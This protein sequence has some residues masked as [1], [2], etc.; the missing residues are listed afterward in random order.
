MDRRKRME[1]VNHHTA[2]LLWSGVYYTSALESLLW[3]NAWHKHHPPPCVQRCETSTIIRGAYVSTSVCLGSLYVKLALELLALCVDLRFSQD[4][5]IG[6]QCPGRGRSRKQSKT[7][8]GCRRCGNG[9][10]LYHR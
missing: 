3:L 7:K 9:L 2:C 4:V 8:L 10:A 1:I 5:E 6:L